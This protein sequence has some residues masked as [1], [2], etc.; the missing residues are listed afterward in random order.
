MFFTQNYN[1]I[2]QLCD[3]LHLFFLFHM[4]FIDIHIEILV[5]IGELW[6]GFEFILK[7]QVITEINYGY[8]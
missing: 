7:I 3:E 8:T 4:Q 6:S 1:M 2:K 5:K